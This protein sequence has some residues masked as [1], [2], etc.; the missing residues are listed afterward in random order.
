MAK[1]IRALADPAK[2]LIGVRPNVRGPLGA[3][4]DP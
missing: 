4:L 1:F 2:G 3:L